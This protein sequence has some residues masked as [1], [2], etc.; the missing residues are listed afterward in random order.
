MRLQSAELVE[1]LAQRYVV[2]TQ[3]GAARRR[4][5]S[6]IQQRA[7]VREAVARWE[8]RLVPL[9]WQLEPM[10]PSDLLW[11]RIVRQTGAGEVRSPRTSGAGRGVW[12]GLA[13]A[14]AMLAIFMA[15]GWWNAEQRPTKIVKQTVIERVTEQV[16]VALV[17][18]EDGE[19]L[20]LTRIGDTSG[21]L[22]VRV[23]GNVLAQPGNDYQLW[24]LTDAGVPVSLGLLPQSGSLTISLGSEERAALER[25]STLAVSLE[26][27]GGSPKAV[28]TGPVLYTAPLLAS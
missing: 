25:S 8:Q 23:V 24:A 18:S 9:A 21:E 11:Q 27:P 1:L 10:T 16:S 26:P 17:A 19:A 15:G 4:F 7:D 14:C 2:G 3:Q 12:R 13:A 22:A 5:A 28:P 20:W 6:L